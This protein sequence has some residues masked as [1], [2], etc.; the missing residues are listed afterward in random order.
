M[1][2][3]IR[4]ARPGWNTRNDKKPRADSQC[5]HGNAQQYAHLGPKCRDQRRSLEHA[6]GSYPADRE[7]QRTREAGAKAKSHGPQG[8]EGDIKEIK[9]TL[10]AMLASK[11]RTWAQVAGETASTAG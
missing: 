5:S 11:S 9:E 8:V 3:N 4:R 2:G 1:R 10:K 7:A 6:K